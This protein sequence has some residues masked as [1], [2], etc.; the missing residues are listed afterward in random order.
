VNKE[1]FKIDIQDL[2]SCRKEVKIEIPQKEVNAAYNR[3]LT[4]IKGQVNLPGFRAGKAPKGILLKKYARE[5]QDQVRQDIF[6]AVMQSVFEDENSAPVSQP[7][8]DEGEIKQNEA[9]SFS[10]KYDVSPE[11][12]LPEYK[13]YKLDE[14]EVSLDA[15]EVEKQLE[16]IRDRFAKLELVERAAAED[17]FVKCDYRGEITLAEGDAIP[18]AAEGVLSGEGRW[19]PVKE[20]SLLPAAMEN[21]KGKKAADKVE[22][23]T[24][25]EDDYSVEFLQGKEVKYTCTVTEV[26]GRVIPELTDELAKEAGAEDLVDLKTKMEDGQKSQKQG[27][28]LNKNKETV[29]EKVLEGFECELPP[30]LLKSEIERALHSLKHD[31]ELDHDC[32]DHNHTHDDT[33]GHSEEQIKIEEGLKVEAEEKAVRDL[34]TRFLLRKIAKVEEVKVEDF[35]IQYQI[36][37][38]AQQYRVDPKVFREQLEANGSMDEFSEQILIDKTLAKIVELNTATKEK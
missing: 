18:E 37:M 36:Y 27:E 5:I 22:W 13:S 4:N 25:F 19:I 12:L 14:T 33:C 29:L 11:V 9:Y 15:E 1:A 17:D 28:L 6:R 38:M 3:T 23:T 35:E 30:T 16:E 7:E 32:A 8:I 10:M 21:L 2:E 31:K 26:H 24:K 20:Q 34:K